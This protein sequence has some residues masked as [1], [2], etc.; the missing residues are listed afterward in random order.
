[1]ET[2]RYKFLHDNYYN[3]QYRK[4]LIRISFTIILALGFFKLPDD[5]HYYGGNTYT[6]Q[7]EDENLLD[8]LFCIDVVDDPFSSIR[9]HNHNLGK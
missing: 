5:S 3:V 1:M 7:N 4:L 6:D 8:E 2:I 9:I